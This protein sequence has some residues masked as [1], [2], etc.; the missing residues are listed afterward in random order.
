MTV[1]ADASVYKT[2]IHQRSTATTRTVSRNRSLPAGR[3]TWR[4]NS[5]NGCPR[6]GGGTWRTTTSN[7]ART[8]SGCGGLAHDQRDQQCEAWGRQCH[9]DIYHFA[10]VCRSKA[11]RAVQN[12]TA[13]HAQCVESS[14]AEGVQHVSYGEYEALNNIQT[15]AAA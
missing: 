14:I 15:R 6:T 1:D 9:R 7:Q 5:N 11:C 3:G 13:T 10:S 12:V 8:Y 4:A 2:D